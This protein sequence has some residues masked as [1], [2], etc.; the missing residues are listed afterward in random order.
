LGGSCVGDKGT[1]GVL[2]LLL[3]IIIIIIIRI[4]FL[5][6]R[7]TIG[8]KMIPTRRILSERIKREFRDLFVGVWR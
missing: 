2:L 1:K 8:L 3:L 4:G 7:A 6:G 5:C